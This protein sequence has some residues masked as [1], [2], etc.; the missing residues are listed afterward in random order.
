MRCRRV[1]GPIEGG[2]AKAA[3][4]ERGAGQARGGGSYA[5]TQRRRVM[6]PRISVAAARPSLPR[7]LSPSLTPTPAGRE[8]RLKKQDSVTTI[9]SCFCSL[10]PL[11]AGV[12]VRMG[13][14][15]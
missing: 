8:G 1:V 5:L 11:P 9:A 4:H 7:P 3:D 13:E 14:E 10:P 2:R 12:G 6:P 15:G